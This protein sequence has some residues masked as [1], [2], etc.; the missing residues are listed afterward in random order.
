MSNDHSTRIETLRAQGVASLSAAPDLDSLEQARVAVLGRKGPLAEL[1]KSMRDLDNEQKRL[2][3]GLL[4]EAR[5]ELEAT[6]QSRLSELKTAAESARLEADRIDVT[7]PGRNLRRGHPHPITQTMDRIVDAFVSM[8]YRVAEGP[9]VEDDWHNFQALNMPPDHPARSMQD[10]LYLGGLD[11]LL[12]THTSPVQIRAMRENG[13]VSLEIGDQA[14]LYVVAP[15]RVYRRDPFDAYHSPC[16]HQVEGLA[17]DRGISFAD[18]KGTLAAF[19]REILGES[20]QIRLRP[21]YFPFVEPG[22]EVDVLCVHC[23]GDGCA[24]CGRTGWLEIM[25]AGMVHPSVLEAGGYDSGLVS[26]FAFGMG[27]ERIAMLVHRVPDIRTFW[28]N[29]TR[30]LAAFNG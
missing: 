12:R 5:Q 23:G 10:T 7:L 9:E 30:F 17:V 4:N 24:S 26:G 2:V 1:S 3:G 16:F 8:G 19:A 25:G 27:V 18:L 29:D 21:S 6:H 14:P 13:A 22:A 11:L 15:G 20:Q 28:D